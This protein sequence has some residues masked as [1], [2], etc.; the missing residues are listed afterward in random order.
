VV[1]GGG[2]VRGFGRVFLKRILKTKKF[3][4]FTNILKKWITLKSMRMLD[5]M[6]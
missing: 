5:V 3:R 1:W 4:D 2:G 6:N